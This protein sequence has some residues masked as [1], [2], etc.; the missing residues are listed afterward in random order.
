MA[1]SKRKILLKE[2]SFVQRPAGCV[3]R[4]PPW[5]KAGAGSRYLGPLEPLSPIHKTTPHS[6]ESGEAPGY[7]EGTFSRMW[8]HRRVTRK[9]LR[10]PV[11]SICNWTWGKAGIAQWLAELEA[12][13][14]VFRGWFQTGFHRVPGVRAAI[15][16]DK[17][18]GQGRLWAA[19]SGFIKNGLSVIYFVSGFFPADARQPCDRSNL[20]MNSCSKKQLSI[21]KIHNLRRFKSILSF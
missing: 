1:D 15:P 16:G 5:G 2:N 6:P 19:H 21:K 3:T 18:G 7:A 10:F 14:G 11:V 13:P 20:S 17:E 9:S 12:T 8:Q 4:R